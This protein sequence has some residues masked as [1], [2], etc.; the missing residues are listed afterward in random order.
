MKNIWSIICE[1][2][3][4]DAQTNLLSLFNCVE[5]IQLT[6]DKDKMPKSDKLVIPFNLQ[7]ISFWIIKD[8]SKDNL[9]EIK[10][11]LVDPKGKILNEFLV[12]LKAG[13]G[14]KRLRSITNIQGIQI[15]EGGRYYYKVLQKKGAKFEVASE[16]PLD[17]NLSYKILD[18]N[19]S[20]K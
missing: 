11:D 13:K 14:E 20:S 10:I 17:I 15:T 18:N 6:I 2:S 8:S 5:E 7:I 4:I 16:T 19:Q 9:T 12:T 3:S 1:K